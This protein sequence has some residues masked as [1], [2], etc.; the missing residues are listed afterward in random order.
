MVALVG[1]SGC[2]KTMTAMSIL[3]LLPAAAKSRVLG[4]STF[5]STD[6]HSQ[7]KKSWNKLRGREIA[8]IFQE[9]AAAL[10]PVM[11][12]GPQIA[13]VLK[14]HLG[15]SSK[16]AK[17]RTLALF[18]EVGLPDPKLHWQQHPFQMSGGMRQRAMIAMSLS[19]HPDL[20]IADEP[21]TALDVTLQQHIMDLL[22]HLQRKRGMACLL[23]THDLTLVARYCH[24]IVIMYCGIIV[25]QGLAETLLKSP[26]H[27]YT[28]A[29][30]E[31][32]PHI[33][34]SPPDRLPV[35]RGQVPRLDQVPRGCPFSDRCWRAS[36]VCWEIRPKLETRPG[37]NFGVEDKAAVACHHPLSEGSL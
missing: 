13:A 25:E 2:G 15:L 5:K 7:S 8:A 35:I 28:K 31:T 10:N 12:M 11:A 1:E 21:T 30:I 18:S 33:V 19:C 6:L 27:P 17:N 4:T 34:E 24:R 16:E 9:P 26:K 3:G 22:I 37:T 23:V 36:A 32:I 29:L 20:L 14:R